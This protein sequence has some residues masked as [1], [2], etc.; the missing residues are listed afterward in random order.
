MKMSFPNSILVTWSRTTGGLVAW[1]NDDASIHDAEGLRFNESLT[2]ASVSMISIVAPLVA[3]FRD[4]GRRSNPGH[5][6]F[7]PRRLHGHG[8]E[9][10]APDLQKSFDVRVGLNVFR[11]VERDFVFALT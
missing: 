1:V 3:E 11:I 6:G 8:L 2:C 7:S 4:Q 9:H 10:L 5:R